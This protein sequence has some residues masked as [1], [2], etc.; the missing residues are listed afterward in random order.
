MSARW[1]KVVGD[2][3]ERP[4][5]TLAVTAA[6]AIGTAMMTAALGARTILER[7]VDASFR[8]ANP[9]GATLWLDAVDRRLADAVAARPDVRRRRLRRPGDRPR[10][11]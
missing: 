2:L 3:R 9:P 5:R 1:R 10:L 6:I 11:P 8:G 4:G 7:E